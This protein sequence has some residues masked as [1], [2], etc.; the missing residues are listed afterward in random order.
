MLKHCFKQKISMY[1][2]ALVSCFVVVFSWK[3]NF[4]ISAFVILFFFCMKNK[5]VGKIFWKLYNISLH[6]TFFQMFLFFVFHCVLKTRLQIRSREEKSASHNFFFWIIFEMF[7]FAYE[8]F[9]KNKHLFKI[10]QIIWWDYICL[11]CEI[12]VSFIW[13]FVWNLSLC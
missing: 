10:S 4:A 5:N 6:V 13:E 1:I 9:F 3:Y 2:L 12:G 11:W 8:I 7:C